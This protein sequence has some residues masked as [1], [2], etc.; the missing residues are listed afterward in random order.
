[1]GKKQSPQEWKKHIE[2]QKLGTQTRVDYCREQGLTLSSFDYWSARVR[3][4]Q[5][6]PNEKLVRIGFVEKSA[7]N[8]TGGP[9]VLYIGDQYRLEIPSPVNQGDVKKL[10]D[11][12]GTNRC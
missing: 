3:K 9:F 5:K 7:N 6:G 4:E 2:T 11:I 1:M 8:D 12:L 10:I